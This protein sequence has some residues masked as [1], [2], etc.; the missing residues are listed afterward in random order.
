MQM[1]QTAAL[2]LGILLLG[3]C[4]SSYYRVTDPATGT[5]YYTDKVKQ[6]GSGSVSL[7]D[8]A[9]GDDVTLQNSQVT[10]VSKE[11]FQTKRAGSH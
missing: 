2:V 10:K 9:I 7:R 11:E 3:G 8:A 5:V 4:G 6:H 1:T